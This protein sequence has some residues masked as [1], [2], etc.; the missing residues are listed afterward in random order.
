M[1]VRVWT[2]GGRLIAVPCSRVG[3]I[4]RAN[5]PYVLPG[6]ADYVIAHNLARMAD[7]WMDN[8]TDTFYAYNPR[9]S[10]E[11]TNVTERKQLRERLQ[12]KPFKWFLEN[13]FPESPF[14]IKEYKVVE[15]ERCI[16]CS[17]KCG[18]KFFSHSPL[19][20]YSWN[21]VIRCIIQI[22]S[23]DDEDTC[24]DSMGD[25]RVHDRNL[26]AKQCHQQ[27]WIHLNISFRTELHSE[28]TSNL[29]CNSQL[30]MLCWRNQGGNQV[31]MLTGNDEIREKKFC[32]D[33]TLP[34]EPVKMLDCH[35]LGGN[36]KWSYDEQVSWAPL[37][38]ATK[39]EKATNWSIHVN[40][41]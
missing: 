15:V 10:R 13:I 16:I 26:E 31:F 40:I 8:Y 18:W 21:D 2:C 12:C 1:S 3:H 6:G 23:L 35:G 25:S 5:S 41:S 22:E 14:N 19:S 29:T 28:K 7:V 37:L 24:L 38:D 34:G 4:F 27:V 30:S 36:Q 20:V 11:R 33:A 17:Q 9:A 39:A 32:L